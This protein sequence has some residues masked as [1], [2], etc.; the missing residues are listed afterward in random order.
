MSI[1]PV[2]ARKQ[3]ARV[4]ERLERLLAHADCPR[5]IHADLW[6]TNIMAQ[7]DEFGKWWICGMLDPLCKY[8][9][10]EA[11]IAYMELFKTVTPAFLRAYQSTHRLP[12]EYHGVRKHVYQMYELINHLQLFGGEYLKPLLLAVDKVNQFV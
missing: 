8:A 4:H 9:H 7:P 11:E 3:I 2:K 12:S 10:A 5:L 1:L 6:S